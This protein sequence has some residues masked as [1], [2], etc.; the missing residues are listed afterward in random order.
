MVLN[1]TLVY[2][3][4]QIWAKNI[5]GNRDKKEIKT[6]YRRVFLRCSLEKKHVQHV[7]FS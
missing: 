3:M 2:L 4:Y 5:N 6:L 1:T 7:F